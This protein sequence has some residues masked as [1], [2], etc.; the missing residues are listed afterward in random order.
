[1]R[2]VFM[3]LLCGASFFAYAQ[4]NDPFNSPADISPAGG[5]TSGNTSAATAQTGEA[6]VSSYAYGKSVW[7]RLITPTDLRIN[8]KTE[9]SNY[10]TTLALYRGANIS[11]ARLV[12]GND[13]ASGAVL[14]SEIDVSIQS[15]TYWLAIDGYLGA[16]GNYNLAWQTISMPIMLVLPPG[17]NFAA[18]VALTL[19]EA[20]TTTVAFNQAATAEAGEPGAG[21]RSLWYRFTAPRS[22]RLRVRTLD[23]QF[24]SHIE[25]YTGASLGSLSPVAVND[26]IEFTGGD[27]ESEVIFDA[28]AGTIY[29]VRLAARVSTYGST[30]LVLAPAKVTGTTNLDAAFNG[31]W[32]NP[33][34][35][36]EGVLLDI[37][38]HPAPSSQDVFL[39]FSWY[40]YDPNGNPVYLVGGGNRAITDVVTADLTF[41]VVTT[42]GARFG[43]A[44]NPANVIR[45]PWGTVTLRIRNCNQMDL[46]YAPAV[47]G[48]GAAGTIRLERALSRGPGLTCP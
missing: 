17:D 18:A 23:S 12:A 45:D 11:E 44:F 47:A 29:S 9:G 2:I 41:P 5:I 48:W 32:W 30:K 37:G 3:L 20:G 7:F 36:G 26:D 22:E 34:R 46:I 24:D 19:G 25:I 39:F 33:L 16:V 14:W 43:A 8:A 6:G 42:R 21:Q 28:T 1:M 13:D 31:I 10:D 40:T 15:G 4:A 35:D 27:L 38:D